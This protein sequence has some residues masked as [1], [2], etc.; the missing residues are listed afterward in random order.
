M[1][2]AF[3]REHIVELGVSLKRVR[4]PKNLKKRM[5]YGG[6]G[7]L[8][9]PTGQRE[10]LKQIFKKSPHNHCASVQSVLYCYYTTLWR[11]VY[12]YRRMQ[13]EFYR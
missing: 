8:S 10:S 4:T 9:V 7:I 1:N 2:T 6:G 13:R 12:V 3:L 11:T 5:G